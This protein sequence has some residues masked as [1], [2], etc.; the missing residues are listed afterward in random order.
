MSSRTAAEPGRKARPS[1]FSP[2]RKPKQIQWDKSGE[3]DFPSGSTTPMN[4]PKTWLK[5][6]RIA[7]AVLAMVAQVIAA[8][9]G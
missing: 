9:M 8:C 2:L 6:L 1:R 3:G 4:N 5:A 7:A